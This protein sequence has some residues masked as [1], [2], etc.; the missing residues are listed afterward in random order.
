MGGNDLQS[1]FSVDSSEQLLLD[2]VGEQ[3]VDQLCPPCARGLFCLPETVGTTY[4]DERTLLHYRRLRD[5]WRSA[6][7][8]CFF[9]KT[10]WSQVIREGCYANLERCLS[11]LSAD[12]SCPDHDYELIISAVELGQEEI[13]ATDEDCSIN[14]LSEDLMFML[15][16]EQLDSKYPGSWFQMR[17]VEIGKAQEGR[18]DIF[19]G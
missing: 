16:N 14:D 11:V 7:R 6:L 15:D 17:P 4:G 18:H 3:P 2:E 12:M 19:V 9:C 1:E 8:G 13:I 5:L 10:C